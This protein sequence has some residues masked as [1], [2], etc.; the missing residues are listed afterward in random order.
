M[1]ERQARAMALLGGLILEDGRRWGD[2][3]MP[4]QLADARAV[5]Q[6]GDGEPRQHFLTRP[7]G[8]SKTTDLAGICLAA[9]LEEL[10]A[11]SRAYWIASDRDQGRLG[12]DAI[13]GLATRSGLSSL[14]RIDQWKA[15]VHA[16]S[17]TLEVLPADAPGAHGLRS[18]FYVIDEAAQW[19]GDAAHRG[20]WEA[21][22][23]GLDKVPGARLVVLTTA[24]DPAG[25]FSKVYR[26]ALQSPQWRVS[27]VPGP[28][29]WRS[30]RFL[31][32]QRALL[33][34]SA[35]ARL[36]L[37]R[38]AASEDR[39]V[40]HEDLRRAVR[41]DGPQGYVPGNRYV[42]G[43]DVGITNDRCVV[44]VCHAETE[45]DGRRRVVLDFIRRWSGSRRSPVDLTE[46][47][48]TVEGLSTA[49]GGGRRALVR[50]D[51]FQAVGLAQ[52][53]RSRRVPV[54]EWSFTA[55][56]YALMATTLLTLLRDGLLWLPDDDVLLDE[57][58]TVRLKETGSTGLLRVDHD[59]GAHDD[60]TV[61]LSFAAVAVLES[62]W[63][64]RPVSVGDAAAERASRLSLRALTAG[65]G[66]MRF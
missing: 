17:S 53:L 30:A 21:V 66:G 28:L 11:G 62:G 61:A 15:T 16:S 8:G 43:L 25:W 57:L 36:H 26:H 42:L 6:P 46:V 23:S 20:V 63:S 2:A 55:Q 34:D 5:L 12:V 13:N 59:P 4:W 38:W 29:P 47:E 33:T 40:A 14:V 65:I 37:N 32:D 18:P 54:E 52:R 24:G 1:T 19:P 58:A 50:A 45:P 56:R 27:E 49:Y 41:L 39:L 22:T 9:L 10:P 31:D 44:A 64:R 35:Y 51:P 7:R 60:Q 48:R 3:A